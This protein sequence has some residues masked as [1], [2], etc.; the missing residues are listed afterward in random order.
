MS[1]KVLHQ[2]VTSNV[3]VPQFYT[4]ERRLYYFS[5]LIHIENDITNF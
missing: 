3:R 5:I 4:Q 2:T 1:V